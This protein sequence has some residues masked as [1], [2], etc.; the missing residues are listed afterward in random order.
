MTVTVSVPWK[1]SFY[2]A[3][4]LAIKNA[5]PPTIAFQSGFKPPNRGNILQIEGEFS[6]QEITTLQ[7]ILDGHASLSP[8]ASQASITANGVAESVV[9]VHGLTTFNYRVWLSG[10][11]VLSGT[12]SDGSLEYSTDTPGAYTIEVMDGNST[13]Y[14]EV[15]A[16]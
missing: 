8:S 14:V 4:E 16:N 13:G 7:A 10:V 12:I 11:V 9:T 6:S 3:L 2:P 15:V 1:P 5:L